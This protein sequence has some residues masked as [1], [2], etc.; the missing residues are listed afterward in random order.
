MM[1]NVTRLLSIVT[2]QIYYFIKCNYKTMNNCIIA[3]LLTFTER[4]N[5]SS[6]NYYLSLLREAL[7]RST[8]LNFF[9]CMKCFQSEKIKI[10][11]QDH[12]SL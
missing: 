3:P 4:N 11:F 1:K 8:F 9:V 5:Q 6:F 12:K 7:S 10:S 2:R